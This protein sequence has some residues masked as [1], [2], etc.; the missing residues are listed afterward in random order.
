MTDHDTTDDDEIGWSICPR[1][2]KPIPGDED[3]LCIECAEELYAPRFVL[4]VV[5]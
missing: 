5:S 1:C 2:F 4:E 3:A